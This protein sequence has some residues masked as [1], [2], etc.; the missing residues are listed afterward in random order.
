MRPAASPIAIWI[1]LIV[2]Y[3]VWGSTYLG[4]KLATETLSVAMMGAL[5]FLP[6]GL[7]LAG[8]IAIRER[9]RLRRPSRRSLLD[10]SVVGVLLLMGGTGLVAWGQQTVPTG[11]AA[12]MI[13]LVPMWLAV[14]GRVLLGD[15]MPVLAA[16]GIVVG[17]AGVAILALPVG[18]V[19]RLD[20]AGFATLMVAPVCWS[21]GTLYAARRAVLPRPALFAT[22]LQMVAGGMAF[23]ALAA[24]TGEL[25]AF[26]ASA[27]SPTSWL[28]IGYLI[29]VGSLIGY[30][31]FAW[32][33]TV[34]PLARVATYAYVNPV[35]AVILGWLVLG[36]P[37]TPRTLVAGTVIVVAVAMIVTARGR[38]VRTAIPREDALPAPHPAPSG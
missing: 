24:A 5:R 28:G 38:S 6:A 29:T 15:R 22:G 21:L 25:A 18:S 4:M 37:L 10:T 32:L 13:G 1:G 7:L 20:P 30:T 26:D 14:F 35:V 27:V 17:I 12:L 19:D 2:L 23:L 3:V 8:A 34:A 9:G 33:L 36:E 11:I 16:A 31:T